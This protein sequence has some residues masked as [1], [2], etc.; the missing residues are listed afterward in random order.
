[1]SRGPWLTDEDLKEE[2]RLFLEWMD[3]P[4]SIFYKQFAIDRGYSP[5]KLSEYAARCPEF[6]VALDIANEWQ[7]AKLVTQSFW[8]KGSANI[9]KFVL[10][11]KHGWKE[12]QAP[13]QAT[14][15]F[16][17]CDGKSKDLVNDKS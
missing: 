12:S 1:M 10:S 7:E 4:E 11:N 6:K 2:A 17:E 15:S 9:A 5:Q 8:Q 16:Q 3:K 13:A 14:A